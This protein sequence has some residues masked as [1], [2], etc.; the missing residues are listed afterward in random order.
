[1]PTFADF[2]SLFSSVHL[3]PIKELVQ[4]LKNQHYR[5]LRSEHQQPQSS[6]VTAPPSVPVPTTATLDSLNAD[7]D[8]ILDM[9]KDKTY[10]DTMNKFFN[11]YVKKK[12]NDI[13]ETGKAILLE[14]QRS[15]GTGGKFR[16]RAGN[17][18]V[19]VDSETAL[20]SKLSFILLCEDE[21][22]TC[23]LSHG[24][25]FMFIIQQ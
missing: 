4:C 22:Y 1:V 11:D 17:G 2:I 12:Y 15:L 6:N 25:A 7:S 8:V 21:S 19:E 20:Q 16:K 23:I 9:R 24:N 10:R 14:L 18:F 13:A 3:H 5:S